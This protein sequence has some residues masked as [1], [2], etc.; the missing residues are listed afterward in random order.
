M[1][2]FLLDANC[3]LQTV[4]QRPHANEVA[5]FLADVPVD[6]VFITD[7]AVHSVAIVMGR[8][9]MLGDVPNF[10]AV[11]G[12]GRTIRVLSLEVSIVSQVV[13]TAAIYGL[14]FDDAYQYSA[15]EAHDLSIVSFDA[16]FDR[17][18]RGRL[19]PAAALALFISQPQP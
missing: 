3:W 12:F 11:C 7:L 19:T 15:S 16:D 9:K 10:F 13:Q 17:T 1:M 6:R 8:F 2:R 18:P 14:D 5:K 4:R